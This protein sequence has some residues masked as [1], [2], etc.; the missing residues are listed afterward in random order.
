MKPALLK[1][2]VCPACRGEL[3]CDARQTTP[4]TLTAEELA[5]IAGRGGERAA[6]ETEVLTGT[7]TCGACQAVFPIR[8]GVPR[9][10]KDA[11]RDFPIGEQVSLSTAELGQI[12][13]DKHVQTTFSREWDE[14]EYEDQTIWHWTLDGRIATFCEE[15]EI[16]D[17]SAL[18]GKLM[19]DAGCGPALLSMNLSKRY[20][21]EILC[22]DLS[23]VISR[24]FQKNQ[25]NLCHFIHASVHA[26]PLKHGIA[27]LTYSHGVLHHTHDTRKAFLAIAPVTRP[28]GMLYV[29]LYGK[30]KGWNWVKYLV[31]RSIRGINA[32][33][34]KPLQTAMVYLMTGMHLVIRPIKRLLGM[35][36]QPIESMRQMLVVVRDRYTPK[37]AREH[38]EREVTGWFGEAGFTG[39]SRRTQWQSIDVWNG[40]TDLA[41]KGYR[42][43]A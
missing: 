27:D 16:P 26:P 38:T 21:I 6:Y 28:G 39:A 32:R 33:L 7:L 5:V 20:G 12:K 37:F 3:R 9:L 29:W 4:V 11:E 10:Y 17:A 36:V 40:S 15:V 18:H 19:V 42:P 2:L 23:M 41:I 22:M 43:P 13:D 1:Y 14:F 31:I 30:K 35:Q 34:P 25:S 8:G 24:A